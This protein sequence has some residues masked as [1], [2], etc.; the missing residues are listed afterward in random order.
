MLDE[1]LFVESTAASNLL[2]EHLWIV[3]AVGLV[4]LVLSILV[5]AATIK[6]SIAAVGRFIT[7]RRA[8]AVA[9]VASML[10]ISFL[11][12][13]LLL[14]GDSKGWLAGPLMLLATGMAIA[15]IGRCEPTRAI[16]AAV[17]SFVFMSMACVGLAL[18]VAGGVWWFG[19]SD[20]TASGED[21]LAGSV[22]GFGPMLDMEALL[23]LDQPSE[24]VDASDVAAGMLS[25][26]GKIAGVAASSGMVDDVDLGS[27][28]A[29]GQGVVSAV[30]IEGGAAGGLGD[31]TAG[32]AAGG[33]AAGGDGLTDFSAIAG[34]L[35]AVPGG[36]GAPVGLQGS[37][38]DLSGTV[39]DITS[40]SGAGA[41]GETLTGGLGGPLGS[42]NTRGL[43]STGGATGLTTRGNVNASRT[44]DLRSAP[45][46]SNPFFQTDQKPGSFGRGAT[47]PLPDDQLS[48]PSPW[49]P[50]SATRVDQ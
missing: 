7:L 29:V 28:V 3:A 11:I 27:L 42:D 46:R 9:T 23:V 10:S 12:G 2:T 41:A 44:I 48:T 32:M 26:V 4:A 19:A 25:G 45:V 50:G 16:A 20:L 36:R 18:V 5:P 30:E 34:D 22:A 35:N 6:L 40:L 47:K 43:I 15:G 13:Q 49:L 31:L 33:M 1:N 38:G 39:G 21:L 14:L 8:L 37:L 17:L 24:G